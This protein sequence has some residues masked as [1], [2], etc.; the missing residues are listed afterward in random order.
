MAVRSDG[1]GGRV[2]TDRVLPSFAAFA[3]HYGVAV[4]ICPS[5]RGQRKGV[6][7]KN[8]D[9]L[10]R[11]WW[12]TADV[13]TPGTGPTVA[14]C[15]FCETIGDARPRHDVEGRPSTVAALAEAERLG[16]LPA[17]RFPATMETTRKV[18]ANA[19]VAYR[20]NRYS[21]D[22]ALVGLEV[23]IR[24]TAGTSTNRHHRPRHRP[25][26]PTPARPARTGRAGS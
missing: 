18:A 25:A 4:D 15:R 21:V 8:I 3:K 5:R 19:T 16:K 22:P 17:T 2:G 1:H 20:G 9:F 7:E 23:L 26:R 14:G 13:T 6:V 10:A 11:R 24:V 12:R